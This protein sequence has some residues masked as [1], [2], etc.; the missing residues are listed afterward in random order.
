MLKFGVGGV[1]GQTPS[2]E[3]APTNH[4]IVEGC[5]NKGN[6]T[7]EYP[8][9]GSGSYPAFGGVAGIIEGEDL[10]RQQDYSRNGC[11]LRR[12]GRICNPRCF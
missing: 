12:C 9:G 3:N 1:I 8:G 4:G 7:W 10:H 6:L 11:Q 5:T 2:V